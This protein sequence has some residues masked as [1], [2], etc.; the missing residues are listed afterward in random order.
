[1]ANSFLSRVAATFSVALV[2]N[3]NGATVVNAITTLN[4]GVA[5][6]AATGGA[7]V[8]YL[9]NAAATSWYRYL[10]G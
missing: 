8:T 3:G 6:A 1:M 9:Y 10:R 5:P 2:N 7:S 4:A